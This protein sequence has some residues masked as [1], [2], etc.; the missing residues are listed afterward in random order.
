M[1]FLNLGYPCTYSR[2]RKSR[3]AKRW[4]SKENDLTV[5]IV[6]GY[7]TFVP[8]DGAADPFIALAKSMPQILKTRDWQTL[9]LRE[10]T[11]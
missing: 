4:W 9:T 6:S 10:E 2:G 3:G 7:S 1:V 5:I 8:Q 11:E